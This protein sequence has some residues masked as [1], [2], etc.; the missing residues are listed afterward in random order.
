MLEEQETY[1]KNV[2]KSNASKLLTGTQT[3]I[4]F[5]TFEPQPMRNSL[6]VPGSYMSKSQNKLC[7]YMNTKAF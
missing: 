7:K 1:F 6:H 3:C 2:I 5:F 4:L